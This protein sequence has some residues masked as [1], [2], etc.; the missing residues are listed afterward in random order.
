[1]FVVFGA[2]CFPFTAPLSGDSISARCYYFL[3][4]FYG[5]DNVRLFARVGKFC[6]RARCGKQ[7][8]D[9]SISTTCVP[10]VIVV[11]ERNYQ[12]IDNAVS[13]D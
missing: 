9:L 11:F 12:L 7:P 4:V 13:P 6:F 3:I 10:N 5:L 2:C 1:M 8:D